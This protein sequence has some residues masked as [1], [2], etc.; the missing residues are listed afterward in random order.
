MPIQ[1]LN[2]NDKLKSLADGDNLSATQKK[3]LLDQ[4]NTNISP[5][6]QQLGYLP[7]YGATTNPSRSA[8]SVVASAYDTSGNGGRKLVRL[9]NGWV[10]AGV[11]DSTNSQVRFYVSKDNFAT[12]PTQLCY[13]KGSNVASSKLFSLVNVGNRIYVLAHVGGMKLFS[14][15]AT[16]VTNIDIS[17]LTVNTLDTDYLSFDSNTIINNSTTELHACWSVKS[18]AYPN[19]FNIRYAKGT[20]A[21]DGSVT[22]G[23]VEQW[24]SNN[25]TGNDMKNPS[26]VILSGRPIV[27][28]ES[29]SGTSAYV[30]VAF[31]SSGMA[32]AATGAYLK[33]YTNIYSGTTYTQSNPS[34]TVDGAGAIHVVWQGY[35]ATDNS[36]LNIRYSK[37]TDGGVTWS[38]MLKLTSGNTNNQGLPS[39]TYDKNNNLYVYWQGTVTNYRIRSIIYNGTSWGSITDVTTNTTAHIQYPSLCDNH[40]DFT[41][42]LVIWQDNVSPSVKFSG[43]WTDTPLVSETTSISAVSNKAL[44]DAY[45]SA[46][47]PSQVSTRK[48]VANGTATSTSA[49]DTGFDSYY[50]ANV[51]NGNFAQLIV[52]GLTFTPSLIIVWVNAGNV[53]T[54]YRSGADFTNAS[55][56]QNVYVATG[57]G[58]V[59]GGVG[60]SPTYY[61]GFYVKSDRFS[62]PVNS[63]STVYNW[64][65]YE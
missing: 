17:T 65:A 9:N 3:S 33:P 11:F 30:I 53:M 5:I 40:R 20:I 44:I 45:V 38:A 31:S 21:S 59:G 16:T 10:V 48:R 64:V 52:T 27:M 46:N 4:Y 13:L 50:N 8:V 37:S 39:I 55:N 15:D 7:T 23:A 6:S 57:S 58:F 43:T 22:W 28:C 12:T 47:Y 41:S 49:L 54:S 24:T 60:S 51:S 1:S 42:P 2:S 35:D 29:I 32:N 26:V 25:T 18:S 63:T 62:L 56:T 61:A 34:A 19:S 36:S 14:F